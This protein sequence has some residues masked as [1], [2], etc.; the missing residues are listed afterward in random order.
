[1]GQNSLYL[2]VCVCVC[3]RA[4]VCGAF[5]RT[6]QTA[7]K[8]LSHIPEITLPHLY[9]TSPYKGDQ[10]E[11]TEP[12]NPHLLTVFIP[13]L[14]LYFFLYKRD[15]RT[16]QKGEGFTNKT[17][18][19]LHCNDNPFLNQKTIQDKEKTYN[20]KKRTPQKSSWFGQDSPN[21][22]LT[23]HLQSTLTGDTLSKPPKLA[24]TR[25]PTSNPLQSR[26]VLQI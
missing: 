20:K 24:Q 9:Y 21:P 16:T 14:S 18:H 6:S 13:L 23:V 10:T 7:W 11:K 22:R 19:S 25:A 3:L 26:F 1:M 17:L 15:H 12:D 2:R 5:Y 4:R 8:S